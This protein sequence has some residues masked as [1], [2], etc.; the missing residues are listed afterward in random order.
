[1]TNN[2]RTAL[3]LVG[4]STII[5]FSAGIGA[6][7]DSEPA[8]ILKTEPFDRDPGWEAHH[9]HIVPKSVPTIE[10]DFG[11]SRTTLAGK[12]PGE[13]GGRVHRTGKAAFYAVEIAPKTLDD[14]LSASGTFAFTKMD[15][16]SGVFFGFFNAQQPGGSGRPVAS[17]GMNMGCELK[18]GRLAVHVITA[19]NQVV[20]RFITRYEKYRTAAEREINDLGGARRFGGI[21]G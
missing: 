3:G 15:S 19:Q 4:L 8:T 17:F 13:I 2:F 11:Y 18:G 16:G 1:M 21:W 12:E 14:R 7:A 10:Q 20:G 6:A 5:S 9:N